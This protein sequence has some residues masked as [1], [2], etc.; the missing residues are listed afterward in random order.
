MGP[1]QPKERARRGKGGRWYTP[2]R[3]RRFE[4]AVREMARL[5][6]PHSWMTGEHYHVA[7]TAYFPDARARDLD[8]VCKAVLDACNKVLWADDRQ[9]VRVLLSREID[10]ALPRTEV[11]VEI[12]AKGA[13]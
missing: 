8:N 5:M 11:L 1:P 3:T 2:E 12:A 10:R 7:L 9:V 6:A 13:A 4:D